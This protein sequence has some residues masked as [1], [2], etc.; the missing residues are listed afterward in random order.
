MPQRA[1]E[2]CFQNTE[3]DARTNVEYPACGKRNIIIE[4][5]ESQDQ[6][7]AENDKLDQDNKGGLP[8][9]PM[10]PGQFP[11][12]SAYCYSRVGPKC[13]TAHS[14]T[15]EYQP[16]HIGSEDVLQ[17]VPTAGLIVQS[18]ET[19]AARDRVLEEKA[20]QPVARLYEDS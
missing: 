5:E 19:E 12:L 13:G 7:K 16:G 3:H 2:H 11:S 20:K 14:Q 1:T 8:L 15:K 9:H 6:R 4:G 17:D 18:A 10:K